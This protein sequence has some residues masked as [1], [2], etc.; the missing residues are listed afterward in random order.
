MGLGFVLYN[1]LY[2]YFGEI[3]GVEI[4]LE[5]LYVWK[6][7]DLLSRPTFL[8]NVNF[9]TTPGDYYFIYNSYTNTN[10]LPYR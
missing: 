1:V 10:P 8:E 3:D 4:F 7:M 5:H 9:L 2:L 6:I